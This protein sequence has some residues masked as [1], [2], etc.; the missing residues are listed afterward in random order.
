Y[1]SILED[2]LLAFRIPVFTKKAKR[3]VSVHPKFYFFDT[4]VFR[5][6]RPSGYLDKP[7]EI[8]GSALE[9][10]VVQHLRS[11]NAYRGDGNNIHFWRTYS[12]LEVDFVIYGQDGIWAIEVKNT[13]HIRGNDLQALRA[14]KSDFPQ[15]NALLL[16]RG[17]ERFKIHD[18]LCVSC[19][20]FLVNLHPDKSLISYL[21]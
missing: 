11:W 3:A 13:A 18:I 2:L 10:L 6:L 16:Y 20:E 15:C 21:T 7:E 9:G 5:S 4:G 19:E 8:E 17:K 14:F 1:I 12:G